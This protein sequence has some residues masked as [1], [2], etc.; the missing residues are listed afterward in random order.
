MGVGSGS[1]FLSAPGN[2]DSNYDDGIQF[3]KLRQRS[4]LGRDRSIP[5]HI[6]FNGFG[7]KPSSSARPAEPNR[8]AG[9]VKAECVLV[10]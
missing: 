1:G 6:H 8:E 5:F 7:Y 3:I 4:I 10:E 2:Y 9:S